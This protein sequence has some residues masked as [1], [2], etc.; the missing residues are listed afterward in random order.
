MITSSIRFAY[1]I[2]PPFNFINKGQVTGCDVELARHLLEQI[3]IIKV[4]FVETEFAELLPGLM[5]GEWQ[6]TTGMFRTEK[7]QEHA[8]FSTPIWALQDGLL[9]NPLNTTMISGYRSIAENEALRLAVIRDQVQ[10]QNAL[11]NGIPNERIKVFETYNA[12]A[13][14]VQRGD[15]AAYTSV[16]QAHKGYLEQS[17][18]LSLSVVEVPSSEQ[19]PAFGCYAFALETPELQ[20]SINRVLKEVLGSPFHRK[21]MQTF[22]FSSGVVD[23]V[24]N[25]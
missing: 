17:R 9:I 24:L 6:M 2:E 4:D 1:L 11:S 16:A 18:D 7:R 14:A 3:G 22:G 12:A 10:H 21:L 5:R 20:V 23:A 19:S 13:E 15:V 8:L 25:V